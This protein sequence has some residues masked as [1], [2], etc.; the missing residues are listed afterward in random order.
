MVFVTD[1]LT[2]LRFDGSVWVAYSGTAI[3]Q[4][5]NSLA[6]SINIGSNNDKNLTFKTNNTTRATILNSGNFGI[7]NALPTANLHVR[8]TAGTTASTVF[9][10]DGNAGELFTVT[11]SLQGSLMSVNDI[12]GLPILEVFDDNTVLIG[13]YQAPALNTT[14]KSILSSSTSFQTVY[15]ISKSLY[16]AIFFEYVVSNSSNM[17]AGTIVAVWDGTNIEFNETSTSDIGNTGPV[18]IQAVISG[19]NVLIQFK[20]T[21]SNWTIKAI[22]RS[23]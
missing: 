3:L 23:I 7:N 18:T 15:Q 5:G 8:S 10:V 22:I 21:T 19:S 17:R 20:V 14:V 1:T 2:T 11:D 12:S 6:N 9:K 16:S 13:D 4:N